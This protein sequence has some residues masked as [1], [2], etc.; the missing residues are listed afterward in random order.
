MM[1]INVLMLFFVFAA[2]GCTKGNAQEEKNIKNDLKR[3]EVSVKQV[4]TAEKQ[5]VLL[6]NA[7]PT[8]AVVSKKREQINYKVNSKIKCTVDLFTIIN[9]KVTC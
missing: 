5:E 4:C 8:D 3:S 7:N 1:K 9:D 6:I 2:F